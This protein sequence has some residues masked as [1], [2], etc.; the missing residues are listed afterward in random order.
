MARKN[1]S[2]KNARNKASR[3]RKKVEA[4]TAT[5]TELTWLA[6]YEENKLPPGRPKADETN[7]TETTDAGAEDADDGEA[8]EEEDDSTDVVAEGAGTNPLPGRAGPDHGAPVG[9]APAPGPTPSNAPVAPPRSP[10]VKLP[11]PPRTRAHA[12]EDAHAPKGKAGGDWRDKYRTG[13]GQAAG[14]EVT[15]TKIAEQWRDVLQVFADGI[16]AAG[17]KPLVDPQQLYPSMVLV[18][19]EVLPAHVELT[20]KMIALGG[21][22]VLVVQRFVRRA[23]IAAVQTKHDEAEAMR[24]RAEERRKRTEAKQEEGPTPNVEPSVP[25]DPVAETTPPTTDPTSGEPVA[26]HTNGVRLTAEEMIAQ[27]PGAVF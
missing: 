5:E 18:V 8:E 9:A 12:E 6:E 22:T 10:R 13:G 19:D 27:N 17:I 23:E 26:S 16:A 24:A 4:K 25:A 20:P 11:P 14:R 7:T 2:R 21:T 3:I 1:Q 15:V